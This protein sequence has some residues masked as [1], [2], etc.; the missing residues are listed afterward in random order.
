[1]CKSPK[2]FD[3]TCFFEEERLIVYSA[4]PNWTGV[5][6]NL[7]RTVVDI[8]KLGLPWLGGIA[9]YIHTPM[10]PP[11]PLPQSYSSQRLLPQFCHLHEAKLFQKK[12][13]N[14]PV[15]VHRAVLVKK[16]AICIDR[17]SLPYNSMLRNRNQLIYFS[18]FSN[19]IAL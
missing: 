18:C 8:V 4:I 7:K 2:I 13:P 5:W 6:T 10:S 16:A 3:S 19:G 14:G 9:V 12:V 17:S 1:M 15:M 11:A